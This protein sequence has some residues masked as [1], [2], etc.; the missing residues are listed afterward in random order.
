[1]K[2]VNSHIVLHLTA[3]CVEQDTGVGILL[4]NIPTFMDM[5]II[6]YGSEEKEWK[7]C[8]EINVNR[9]GKGYTLTL[10][11]GEA[12]RQRINLYWQAQFMYKSNGRNPLTT[13]GAVEL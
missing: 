11:V 1:M 7:N 12:L 2:Y 6:F 8:Y 3:S 13:S 4:E 10:K 5:M 9:I